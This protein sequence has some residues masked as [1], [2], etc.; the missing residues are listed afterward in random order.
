MALLVIA[1]CGS[2]DY[3]NGPPPDAR[4]E[5]D[6][7]WSITNPAP[8][9]GCVNTACGGCSSWLKWDGTPSKPGDPC[10]W[11]GTLQC[12]GTA[13]QCSDS[14]CL[15]CTQMVSGSVCGAD[16]HT[17]VTLLNSGGTCSAYDEGS[18][19]AICNRGA[20][21]SCVDRCVQDGT[22]MNWTCEGHCLSD[23]DGGGAGCAHKSSDTCT[24]LGGC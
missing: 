1:G 18:A 17:I 19:L 5:L 24:T 21:D 8:D 23:P 11:Q 6:L 16:G 20:S 22:T 10:L 12:K 13:L 4:N 9:G 14:S 7:A 3:T 15:P 2:S